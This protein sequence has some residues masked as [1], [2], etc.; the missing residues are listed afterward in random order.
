[1]AKKLVNLEVSIGP[2]SFRDHMFVETEVDEQQVARGYFGTGDKAGE[3][4]G[5][6]FVF[7][8]CP[9][10]PRVCVASVLEVEDQMAELVQ[11]LVRS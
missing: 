3:P 1:M 6:G 11:S 10:E 4:E 7:S 5:E 8:K 9:G 2:Y